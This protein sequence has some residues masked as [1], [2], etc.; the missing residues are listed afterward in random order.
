MTGTTRALARFVV[1]SRFDTLPPQV[2]HEGVRAFVNWIGCAA[3]GAREDCVEKALGLLAEF[4]G[5]REA[6]V[7]GRGE[8]LDALNAAFV[9]SMSSSALSFN[10]THYATV[11]HPTSPVAAALFAL[12]QRRPIAGRDFVHALALGDEIQCRIGA[13]LCTAPAECGVGLSMQGLVGGIG[14]A[15]AAARVLGFD[16][17]RMAIAIG[18]AANQ[19]SGLREAHATM[20]SPFTPGHAARCGL[21]AALLAGRGYTCSDSMLEGVKG[22]AVSF[23]LRPNLDAAVDGLGRRYEI[24]DLA[25]KPYPCGFVIHPIIDACLD[26]A[27]RQDFDAAQVERIELTVNPLALQLCNRPEPKNRAHAMVSLQ[28]WTA[29]SLLHKLAGIAQVTDAM[30]HDPAVA[31]LRSRVAAG[32][33]PGVAREAATARVTLRNGKVFESKVLHSIGSAGYPLSDDDLSTKTRGQLR[34]AYRDDAAERILAESWRIT[35]LPRVDAL[36]E[37]A[38]KSKDEG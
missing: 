11:A 34:L 19:S 10:D 8:R 29:V 30:V 37:M 23:G 22:F 12:A 14:A 6:V 16:E 3:G 24:L 20:G 21:L 15:A 28:H 25:Y 5:A 18:L 27:R 2:A 32:A 13:I 33:D 35:E 4:N 31:G 36:C 9:N 26:I 17:D 38:G 1:S 7:V